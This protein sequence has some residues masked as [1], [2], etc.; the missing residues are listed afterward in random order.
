MPNKTPIEW[1]DYSS[2]PIYA[3]ATATGK[4]GWHCVGMGTE[5]A[6]CY[7]QALNRRVGTGLPFT[8]EAGAQITW[9]LNTTELAAYQRLPAG[10]MV[11][12]ADMIDLFQAGIPAAD[13]RELG[14]ALRAAPHVRFL[15]LTKRAHRMA[16]W[17]EREWGPVPHVYYGT[18]VGVQAA[19]PRLRSL[20][21]LADFGA[22]LF[23]SVEP[24]VEL[25][26]LGLAGHGIGGVLVGGES[27]PGA[28]PCDLAWI[29]EV[30][31]QAQAAGARCFVK[32][33][34]TAWATAHH[35]RHSKGGDPTAWPVDLRVRELLWGG[36]ADQPVQEVVR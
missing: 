6:H 29:R 19:T 14:A 17:V 11:F 24:L 26:A 7:A 21:R 1:A 9:R 13:L 32:Q 3:V 5:C 8:T 15:V 35:A 20:S 22:G 16:E 10:A 2:N 25:V 33:L 23:V 4:R 27:G 18:S 31:D 28:R 30:R 12:V 34:G 36:A